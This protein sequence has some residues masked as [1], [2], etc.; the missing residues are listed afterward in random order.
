LSTPENP[1]KWMKKSFFNSLLEQWNEELAHKNYLVKKPAEHH[2]NVPFVDWDKTHNSWVVSYFESPKKGSIKVGKTRSFH[3]KSNEQEDIDA[4]LENAKN[5]AGG[6]EL[7]RYP[8]KQSS[9]KKPKKSKS[10]AGNTTL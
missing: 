4:A 7:G 3:A 2:S 10:T 9:T 5:F 6:V 1:K 8:K